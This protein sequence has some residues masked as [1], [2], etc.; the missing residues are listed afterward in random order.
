MTDTVTVTLG[1]IAFEGFELPEAM[2]FGGEQMLAIHK[3]IG[4]ERVI[5]AMGRDDAA[6]EWTARFIGSDA[7]SRA[8][9]IDAI[10]VGGAAASLTWSSFSKTVVVRAFRPIYRAENWLDYSITC[11]VVKDDASPTAG[12]ETPSLDS[13]ISQDVA[14][15]SA[16]ASDVQTA[17]SVLN[18]L[19]AIAAN[20]LGAA[21]GLIGSALDLSA[22]ASGLLET[23]AESVLTNSPS[24]ATV[25]DAVGA[26][27]SAIGAPASLTALIGTMSAAVTA[28][29]RA[30]S[31][32]AAVAGV[33]DSLTNSPAFSF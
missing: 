23:A 11:E 5:D 7:V 30:T 33:A 8:N 19:T 31:P 24:F 15:V 14:T 29:T 4:G 27:A 12:A 22:A 10:R 28:V 13:Q 18:T 3:L 21:V 9:A 25:A 6:I 17:V 26:A 2:P 32:L 16:L 20:P 1:G